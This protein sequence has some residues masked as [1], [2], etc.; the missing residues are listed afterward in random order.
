MLRS[1]GSATHDVVSGRAN[2][3]SSTKRRRTS[4]PS[5]RPVSVDL[6]DEDV[7]SGRSGVADPDQLGVRWIVCDEV[8]LEHA[9]GQSIEQHEVVVGRVA[10]RRSPGDS[11]PRRPRTSFVPPTSGGRA[12]A[13]A[14]R[15]PTAGR[16]P[17]SAG[18][19]ARRRS[20]PRVEDRIASTRVQ[21]VGR[22]ERQLRRRRSTTSIAFARASPR[23]AQPARSHGLRS[24]GRARASA[25]HRCARTSSRARS[26]SRPSR[27]RCRSP[28]RRRAA[29]HARRAPLR[30][31]AV[32][33]RG[34]RPPR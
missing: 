3:T 9:D 14:S 16:P 12:G 17:P 15:A 24:D 29:P 28:S 25:R 32:P 18:T 34:N 2:T 4:V 10:C 26:R 23:A 7:G 1:S 27:G 13:G 8:G 20:L 6:A 19:R 33:R 11:A 22:V 5:P 21:A 31:G 30:P